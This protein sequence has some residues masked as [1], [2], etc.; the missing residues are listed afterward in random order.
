MLRPKRY[1]SDIALELVKG[2]QSGEIVLEHERQ[3][4]IADSEEF[5]LQLKKQ[6]SPSSLLK[7]IA[8]LCAALILGTIT[9]VFIG[10]PLHFGE[11]SHFSIAVLSSLI[12]ALCVCIVALTA[13]ERQRRNQLKQIEKGLQS[14]RRSAE[15]FSQ[16]AERGKMPV[17]HPH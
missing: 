6:Y 15:E 3:G 16:Q 11:L 14:L 1:A 10:K 9:P 17:T 12:G 13:Y 5:L 2:L 8:A 7:E 4:D